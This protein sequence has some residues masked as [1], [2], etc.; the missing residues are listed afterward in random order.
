MVNDQSGIIS[1]KVMTDKMD[2]RKP[3]SEM[4]DEIWECLYGDKGYI[5]DALEW[6]LAENGVT[7]ITGMKKI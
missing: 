7:L 6:E 2:E 4:A 5:S 3:V 1:V